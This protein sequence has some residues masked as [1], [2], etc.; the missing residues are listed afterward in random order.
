M[1][2]QIII[3]VNKFN[4]V[5]F[6]FLIFSL[7]SHATGHEHSHNCCKAHDWAAI[8]GSALGAAPSAV[9]FIWNGGEILNHGLGY[10]GVGEHEHEHEHAK[11]IGETLTK[12]WHV[13]EVI[14]HG[15]N[16]VSSGF[17]MSGKD[18][19][20]VKSSTVLTL[21][22]LL[23]AFAQIQTA[24]HRKTSWIGIAM[25]PFSIFDFAGHAATAWTSSQLLRKWF[26]K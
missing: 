22:N 7:N 26:F 16:L 24:L 17:H 12:Y 19:H 15:S 6:A 20:S 18:L 25:A 9:S 5:F 3:I 14:L 13:A 21:L 2:L 1:Q 11:D 8:A 4:S 10:F 23:G